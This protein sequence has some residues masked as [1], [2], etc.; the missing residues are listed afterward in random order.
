MGTPIVVYM[1]DGR[2]INGSLSFRMSPSTPEIVAQG[3]LFSFQGPRGWVT[4]NMSKVRKIQTF[5]G[6]PT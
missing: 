5:A 4:V 1:N 6:R 3:P 2:Q